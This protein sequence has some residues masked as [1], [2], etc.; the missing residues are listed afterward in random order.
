M[1]QQPRSPIQLSSRKMVEVTSPASQQ[2]EAFIFQRGSSSP[3]LHSARIPGVQA[4]AGR[5]IKQASQKRIK[6]RKDPSQYAY[7]GRPATSTRAASHSL[8]ENAD[9][10][11]AARKQRAELKEQRQKE[12]QKL[13]ATM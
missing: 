5:S 6:R 1:G 4:S 3:A 9:Y 2:I 12:L 10:L 11:E 8:H 13:Q 7:T